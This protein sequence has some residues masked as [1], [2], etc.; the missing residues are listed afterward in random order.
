MEN[1]ADSAATYIQRDG[2]FVHLA[3]PGWWDGA[4]VLNKRHLRVVMRDWAA[5][6]NPG[7]PHRNIGPAF[8]ILQQGCRQSANAKTSVSLGP[9]HRPVLG[10]LHPEYRVEAAAA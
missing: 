2:L 6:Y 1:S 8:H 3:H 5:H 7:R 10:G 4:V 9:I